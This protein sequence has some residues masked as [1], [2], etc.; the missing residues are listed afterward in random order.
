[1]QEA[2]HHGCCKRL[3]GLREMLG[4]SLRGWE[5][6]MVA[7]LSLAGVISLVVGIATYCAAQL[8]RAE[9]ANAKSIPAATGVRDISCG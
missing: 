1:M 5:S 7:S 4:L 2:V 9:L 3:K 8:Q 6:I